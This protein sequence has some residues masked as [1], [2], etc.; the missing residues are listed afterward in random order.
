[1]NRFGL[2]P[3][4]PLAEENTDNGGDSRFNTWTFKAQQTGY[5]G[6]KGSA[7][8]MGRIIILGKDDNLVKAIAQTPNY[9]QEAGDPFYIDLPEEGIGTLY[10]H[11][12]KNPKTHIFPLQEGKYKVR[13]D[14]ENYVGNVK[15]LS[16]IHI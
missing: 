7:D 1:M 6:I 10:G 13:V 16:L 2:S 15:K 14:V 4:P 12:E 11:R 8:N 3:F 9:K 5:Y